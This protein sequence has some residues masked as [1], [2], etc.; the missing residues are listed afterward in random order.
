MLNIVPYNRSGKDKKIHLGDRKFVQQTRLCSRSTGTHRLAPGGAESQAVPG[1]LKFR[2]WAVRDWPKM[3]ENSFQT[4][5]SETTESIIKALPLVARKRSG[6]GMRPV[7]PVNVQTGRFSAIR[8]SP[9]GQGWP[10][11]VPWS[12]LLRKTVWTHLQSRSPEFPSP[13]P[14]QVCSILLPAV[15]R[16]LPVCVFS[17]FLLH[18]CQLRQKLSSEAKL[19]VFRHQI[20]CLQCTNNSYRR[21][22]S[23]VF[24]RQI[25]LVLF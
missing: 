24:K 4:T 21:G 23:T 1:R 9:A 11:C 6:I 17:V 14:G 25:P 5:G 2:V 19:T 20:D 8:R 10:W 15:C 16:W 13:P 22:N 7:L 12:C 3:A 18:I